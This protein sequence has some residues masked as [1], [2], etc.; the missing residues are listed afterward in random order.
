V[1]VPAPVL[2]PLPDQAVFNKKFFVK[3]LAFLMFL[4][5]VL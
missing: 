3:N 4:E 1:P 5:A 2:A